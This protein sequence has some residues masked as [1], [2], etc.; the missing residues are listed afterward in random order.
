MENSSAVKKFYSLFQEI[1]EDPDCLKQAA[2]IM[3]NDLKEELS[4]IFKVALSSFRPIM[5]HF[6][7]KSNNLLLDSTPEFSQL[8]RDCPTFRRHFAANE[9]PVSSSR[10]GT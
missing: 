1:V 2:D 8:S 9:L 5:L 4:T 3:K 10:R 6:V 7:L